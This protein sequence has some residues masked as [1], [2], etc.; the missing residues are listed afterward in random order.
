M[1]LANDQDHCDPDRQK[2]DE[3]YP[4]LLKV[5]ARFEMEQ[6]LTKGKGMC[7]RRRL[8]ERGGVLFTI[9]YDDGTIKEW[10]WLD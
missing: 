1:R 10:E 3:L 8:T 2:I 5:G 9:E 4:S 6:G 7:L